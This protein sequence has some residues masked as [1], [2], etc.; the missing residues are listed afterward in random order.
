MELGGGGWPIVHLKA[1]LS[2]QA[3]LSSMSHCSVLQR[4]PVIVA[5]G[6]GHFQIISGHTKKAICMVG[7]PLVTH[8]PWFRVPP[9]SARF[10]KELRTSLQAL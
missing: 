9:L 6:Q 2:P 4:G 7:T 1:P 5:R 8:R 10:A 3:A